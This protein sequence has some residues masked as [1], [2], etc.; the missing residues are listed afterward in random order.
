MS[1]VGVQI[2]SSFSDGTQS[3]MGRV[4]GAALILGGIGFAIKMFIRGRQ[5]DAALLLNRHDKIVA[6]LIGA[7]CGFVVGLT[8]VGSGT[9]FGLAMV[10][11]W[12]LTA[13]RI[14]GTDLLHAALLLWVAG[15]GHLLHGNVDLHAMAWLLVGSIPGVLIGSHLSVR[16]PERALRTTFAF[17]LILSGIKLVEVPGATTIIEVGVVLGA[18]TL[19]TWLGLQFRRVRLSRLEPAPD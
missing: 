11:L 13:P 3:A 12:P 4:V 14:V 8:S 18:L 19:V 1:L 2:A 16:V 15:A 9:F 6:I 10:L 7:T 5:S 17:V